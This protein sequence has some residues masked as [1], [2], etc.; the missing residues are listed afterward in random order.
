M[1]DSTMELLLEARDIAGKKLAGAKERHGGGS[2]EAMA[3]MIHS[4]L[5]RESKSRRCKACGERVIV[6]VVNL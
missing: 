1:T 2:V 6:I 3:E 4:P 5:F